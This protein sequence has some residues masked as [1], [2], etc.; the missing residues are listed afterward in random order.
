MSTTAKR[1]DCEVPRQAGE[2]P[3]I[4]LYPRF[5][6]PNVRAKV[7]QACKAG[8]RAAVQEARWHLRGTAASVAGPDG[9]VWALISD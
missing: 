4:G 3:G 5:A 8:C 6:V 7:T 2:R 1:W 9:Y